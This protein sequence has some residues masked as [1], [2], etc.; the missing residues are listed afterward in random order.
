[1]TFEQDFPSLKP[2]ME[3]SNNWYHKNNIKKYCIDMQ[4]IKNAIK[5]NK[6]IIEDSSLN[7][8]FLI[9]KKG[10]EKDLGL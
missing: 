6:V 1:M 8:V 7:K 3:I 5:N 2:D 10:F 9:N 4:K